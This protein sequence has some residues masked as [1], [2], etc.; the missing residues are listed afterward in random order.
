MPELTFENYLRVS[1]ILNQH[2]GRNNYTISAT[3]NEDLKYDLIERNKELE[4]ANDL[5]KSAGWG[6]WILETE[7]AKVQ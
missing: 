4:E 5:V 7:G 3:D 1:E 2:I 6:E